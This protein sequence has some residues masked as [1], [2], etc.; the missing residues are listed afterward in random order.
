MNDFTLSTG[1]N[2]NREGIGQVA[3]LNE[4]S[5][6]LEF[7][8]LDRNVQNKYKNSKCNFVIGLFNLKTI[9]SGIYNRFGY[10]KET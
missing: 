10:L 5:V 4:A 9:N 2:V 3:V 7:S 1:I 8:L 6:V